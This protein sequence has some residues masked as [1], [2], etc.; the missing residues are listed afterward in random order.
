[1]E[2]LNVD[3]ILPKAHVDDP[4]GKIYYLAGPI[5]GAD[6][7]QA[8]AVRIL[9]NLDPGCTIICPCRW[10]NTHPLWQYRVAPRGNTCSKTY[11]RQTDW[12]RYWMP[13]AAEHGCLIFWIPCESAS[14]PRPK[15][16]GPYARDTYGELGRYS[17]LVSNNQDKLCMSIG[18]DPNLPESFGLNQ[19]QRNLNGDFICYYPIWTNL[20]RTLKMA[21]EYAYI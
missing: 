4:C 11:E 17:D 21:V 10:D 13:Y 9:A 8:E 14:S 20:E 19:I 6:D 15:E 18:A 3:L 5:R 7:W 12:E 16:D 2:K 1:M